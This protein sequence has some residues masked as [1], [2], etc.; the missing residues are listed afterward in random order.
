MNG[1]SASMTRTIFALLVGIFSCSSLAADDRK[2]YDY[3]APA[4][5]QDLSC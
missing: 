1:P 4:Q 3:L 5:Q 2:I